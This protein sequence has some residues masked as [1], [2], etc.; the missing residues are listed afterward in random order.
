MIVPMLVNQTR[1]DRNNT[2]SFHEPIAFVK[3][4]N[5]FKLTNEP[6]AHE[7]WRVLLD[8]L[9]ISEPKTYGELVFSA[10]L[11]RLVAYSQ[12]VSF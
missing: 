10:L 1:I 2:F 8:A 9:T 12:L 3:R 11:C 7:L 5:L 6:C 4:H